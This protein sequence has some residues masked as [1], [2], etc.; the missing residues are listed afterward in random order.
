[1]AWPENSP[2]PRDEYGE[3]KGR[4]EGTK[5]P[6]RENPGH[7]EMDDISR[8]IRRFDF[9]E[10]I[11]GKAVYCADVRLDNMLH[12]K[13]LRSTKAR[14]RIVSIETPPLPEGFL[15]VDAG[16]IPGRNVV[17][18]YYDD[19]PFFARGIVNYVGEPILL[20]VGP[21]KDLV[22]R[23]LER[24]SVTYEEMKPV[25]SIEEAEEAGEGFIF[26]ADASFFTLEYS[27]GDPD[28]CSLH[29]ARVFTDEFRTGL[30]EHAYLEP[31]G[32]IAVYGDDGICVSGSMQCPY[33]IKE[34]LVRALG[35]PEERVRVIQLP[36]GGAF[37]GKEEYPSIPAVHAA[38]AAVKARKPVSLVFDRH[39][40]MLCTTKR[41]PS[42]IRLRSFV[43]ANNRVIGREVDI[44][45]DA[46]AYA[47]LSGVVLQ[48]MMF[49]CGGVYDVPNL[50]VTGKA[51]ATNNVVSGAFRG[52]GGPQ[53]FFAIETHMENI[54]DA[55]NLDAMEFKRRHFLHKGDT[56]STGGLFHNEIKLDE[57]A[58]ALERMSGYSR[59]RGLTGPGHGKLKGIG[60]ACFFHGCGFTGSGESELIRARVRL[61]KYQD[62]TVEIFV[63][64]TEIGQG[65]L[66]TL[67][68]IVA[69]TL[70][71]PIETVKHA[72]PDTDQCPDSGP[73]VA[74]RT[75]MIVG[76]LLHEAA[77][78]MKRRWDEE[79][80]DIF[81]V[82]RF[83]EHLTWDNKTFRGNAYPEYAWGGNVVSVEVDPLTFEV[84][85]T[86][87][88]AVY[89]I[90]EP[91]DETIVRGQI[92][93]GII[94]GLGYGG[95]EVM[96]TRD[97]APLQA[98]LTDYAVPTALD[99][100]PIESML[101][102]NP[103]SG[104]PFGARGLG[105]LPLVGAA[106]A[107][108]LAIQNAIGR[109]VTQLPVTPEIIMEM[110]KRDY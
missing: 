3:V 74:S 38:L 61:K 35:W 83:P 7:M 86:G 24:F 25:L 104:G 108:A 63:S 11:T 36:T 12:A 49:S 65:S 32:L 67:R 54:A 78:E 79:T 31:Q 109:K 77:L 57:I 73:T 30:Q 55:L 100:P 92:E 99:F 19:Q 1:M 81:R 69:R 56:S 87:I 105:E 2:F 28:D 98:S 102:D 76:R 33:F 47:G 14:A 71:V 21:D 59:K 96:Q 88:W 6:F 107:L 18:G 44:R 90:G 20:L 4:S 93:G 110:M 37:G 70:E 23:L 50:K 53:V 27:K 42:V 13:T 84:E 8:P 52:F 9:D 5:A 85:V 10:K 15:V 29:A 95:M 39:E 43:D 82:F 94:Q 103:F 97:G 46:G 66:T 75:V 91:V 80:F 26:G 51:F 72:Y 89:D 58:S 40:D 106:P 45:I 60:C 101:I 34:A 68:K 48:R 41:H 22:I 17:P 64:S 62:N 16:D